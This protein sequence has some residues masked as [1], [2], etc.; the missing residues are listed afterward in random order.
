MLGA[1]V[2]WY[3]ITKAGLPCPLAI[4]VAIVTLAALGAL[5]QSD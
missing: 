2:T 1:F 5:M 4:V 3:A